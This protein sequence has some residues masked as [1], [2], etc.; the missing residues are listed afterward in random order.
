MS[1]LGIK[2]FSPINVET[3][4]F[5]DEVL[6]IQTEHSVIVLDIDKE[7]HPILLG[8]IESD[9]TKDTESQFRMSI[10]RDYLLISNFPRTIEEY[11]ISDLYKF[12][13][14]KI[15]NYPLYGY[16]LPENYDIDVSD[17]TDTTY[18]SVLAP[19]NQ[20][21]QIF[22]YRGGFPAVASLYDTIQ[23]DAPKEILIDA[24]GFQVDYVVTVVGS[25]IRMFKQLEDPLAM[26]T[27]VEN[28]T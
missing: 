24:T 15:K 14:T 10:N 6:F 4:V 23:I 22:V 1:K 5:H 27:G 21:R 8:V 17:Q 16:T 18:V 2:Y 7:H 28:D 3:T 12:R 11:D 9:A 13:I 25:T 20:T 19:D 26:A